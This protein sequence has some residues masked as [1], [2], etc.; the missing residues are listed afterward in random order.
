M[1]VIPCVAVV[2]GF[3]PDR[4]QSLAVGVGQKPPALPVVGCANL[5][6]GEQTPFRIEPEVGKVTEDE[7]QA[8]SDDSSHVLQEDVLGSHFTDDAGDVRPEPSFIAHPPLP[9]SC[10]ERLAGESGSDEIHRST[11]RCAV[12][13]AE[14]VPDRRWIQGLVFHPRHEDGRCVGVP[15]NVSHGDCGNSGNAEPKLE[16]SVARAEVEGT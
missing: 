4:D 10:A 3:P 15:L 7:S 6:R 5:G 1:S 13:G 2:F 8:V 16:A 11:P 12:E 9:A 14:I